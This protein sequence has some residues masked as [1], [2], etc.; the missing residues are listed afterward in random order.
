VVLDLSIRSSVD[1]ALEGYSC[2]VLG[3]HRWLCVSRNAELSCVNVV[4]AFGSCRFGVGGHTIQRPRYSD[5]I[6]KINVELIV[7][8]DEAAVAVE[9]NAALN[10]LEEKHTLF[11]GGIESVAFEHQKTRKRSVLGHTIA[12][13]QTVAGAMTIARKSVNAAIRAVI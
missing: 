11:G 9:L 13:A 1:W 6:K 2:R 7:I 12:A 5:A 10:R 8:A 3:N 4:I